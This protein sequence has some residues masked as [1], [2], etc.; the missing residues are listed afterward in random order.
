MTLTRYARTSSF[1]YF[2][3]FVRRRRGVF[4]IS[5]NP[6]DAYGHIRGSKTS[7]NDFFFFLPI[8]RTPY[9]PGR[10]VLFCSSG[11]GQFL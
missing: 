1:F 5:V 8:L 4:L 10:Q 9:P 7:K 3:F 2:Q 11:V 6:S